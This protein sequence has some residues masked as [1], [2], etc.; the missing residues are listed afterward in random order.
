[1]RTELAKIIRKHFDRI[2][3]H[4]TTAILHSAGPHY[5]NANREQVLES[6]R[7]CLEAFL[8]YL[9][10]GDSHQIHEWNHRVT[11]KRAAGAFG[12]K[13]GFSIDEMQFALYLF[14][15]AVLEVLDEDDFKKKQLLEIMGLLMDTIQT[16]VTDLSR[17]YLLVMEKRLLGRYFAPA[18]VDRLVDHYETIF[19]SKSAKVTTFFSDIRGFTRISQL[20]DREEM[21][22]ML[23]RYFA[24]MTELV[25]AHGGT[26]DKFL[27]DGLMVFFGEPEPA[28]VDVQAL[29]AIRMSLKMLEAIERLKTGPWASYA[30]T[31]FSIGIGINTGFATVGH[32]GTKDRM[33]YTVLG[34]NVNLAARL[35]AAA[36][37]GQILVTRRTLEPIKEA[38]CYEDLGSMTF[39]NIAEPVAVFNVTGLK[40]GK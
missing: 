37:P 28:A 23:N 8:A 29:Q 36:K 9:L 31:P 39:K 20:L 17:K 13:P 11:F 35:Q 40:D 38:I 33:E 32:L 15:D 24:E 6:N 34:S 27:G 19:V 10:T 30:E 22:E 21:I 26:L 18:L 25:F 3:Q 5:R 4:W 2:N 14:R 1:M 16:A 7:Q 12:G